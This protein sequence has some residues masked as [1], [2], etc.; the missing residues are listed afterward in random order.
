M[1]QDPGRGRSDRREKAEKETDMSCESLVVNSPGNWTSLRPVYEAG[2]GF[3]TPDFRSDR[4]R[5]PLPNGLVAVNKCSLKNM[6]E[7]RGVWPPICGMTAA[8]AKTTGPTA[9]HSGLVVAQ[10]Y[11]K[12]IS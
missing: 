10:Q 12:I 3:V 9:V 7:V 1:F 8:S 2:R 6:P 11:R 5:F 4:Y